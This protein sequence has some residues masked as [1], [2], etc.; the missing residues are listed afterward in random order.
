MP[1]LGTNTAPPPTVVAS[2]SLEPL[3]LSP[4]KD[5][6]AFLD[7][8]DLIQYYLHV[9]EFSTGR[10]GNTLLTDS[11]NADASQM[12]E[13]QLRLAVKGG[14]IKYLFD[15]KGDLYHGRGFEMLAALM[16]HCRPDSIANAF[17]SLLSL[18]N[19]V[20]GADEPILQY[21]LCISVQSSNPSNLNGDAL[22]SLDSQPLW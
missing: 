15:N 17:P 7:H 1:T 18:F 13:G 3:K 19:D 20:Q 6:Q 2:L 16:Q 22:L 12:W 4:L 8:C 11:L 9:P 21:C 10:A 14:S 5:A